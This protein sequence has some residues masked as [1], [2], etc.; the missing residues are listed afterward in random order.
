MTFCQY[1]TLPS[2]RHVYASP[3]QPSKKYTMMTPTITWLLNMYHAT[4][5]STV[6]TLQLKN[7]GIF[8]KKLWIHFYKQTMG[9]R[10]VGRTQKLLFTSYTVWKL[11]GLRSEAQFINNCQVMRNNFQLDIQHKVKQK[12]YPLKE[13]NVQ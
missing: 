8:I 7:R 3:V 5:G 4:C 2:I 11:T 13:Q 1:V 6:K 12:R 9:S 10:H